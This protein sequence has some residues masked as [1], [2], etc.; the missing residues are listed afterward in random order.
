MKEC[1]FFRESERAEAMV[2]QTPDQS[3]R[4]EGPQAH[5]W[6]GRTPSRLEHQ[7]LNI[8]VSLYRRQQSFWS[9]FTM[10]YQ[11]ITSEKPE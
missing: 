3:C 1:F 10:P 4:V 8:L 9:F 5:P 2:W 11:G 6:A 7:N